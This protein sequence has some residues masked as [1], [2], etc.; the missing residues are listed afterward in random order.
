[1]TQSITRDFFE[2]PPTRSLKDARTCDAINIDHEWVN[3]APAGYTKKKIPYN[4]E[5][6]PPKCS[7]E[8]VSPCFSQSELDNTSLTFTAKSTSIYRTYA[9]CTELSKKRLND[10]CC[11]K[12]LEDLNSPPI[13][14]RTGTSAT[15]VRT[16]RPIGETA[17]FSLTDANRVCPS[18]KNIHYFLSSSRN[19]MARDASGK[20]HIWALV[21]QTFT[22]H[23]NRLTKQTALE[24]GR[25]ENNSRLTSDVVS[26]IEPRKLEFGIF[27]PHGSDYMSLESYRARRIAKAADNLFLQQSKRYKSALLEIATL[28]HKSPR[29]MPNITQIHAISRYDNEPIT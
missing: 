5:M 26:S 2:K 10:H 7:L 20:Q 21:F 6:T 4:F 1:M 13:N 18:N 23:S 3:M 22:R 17:P 27:K 15:D 14:P 8:R 29:P 12:S 24:L 25:K 9:G 11:T 16:D 19:I 28:R